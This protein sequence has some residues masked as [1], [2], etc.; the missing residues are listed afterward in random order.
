[1][2]TRVKISVRALAEY[3]YRGGSIESGFRAA[4]TLLDGTRA[5][6]QLQ[7]DYTERDR[8]EVHLEGRLA[9]EELV[10]ELE[11]RCD[12]LLIGEDGSVTIE[13]IKSTAA[14]LADIGEASHPVHWGQAM[15]YA[16]LYAANEGV[17]ALSIR[18]TYVHV[19][20]YALKRFTRRMEL[21]E[22]E[23][24]VRELVRAYAPFAR[25]QLRHVAERDRSCRALAFPYDAY[26]PGQ[27][28]LAGAVYKSAVDGK[29]LFAR[30]P[31][32]TG[33]TIST[34]FP[35]A[36][37]I[38]EGALDRFYYL[39]ARTITRTAAEEALALLEAKG[40]HLRSATLTAKEKICF[41][42]EMRCQKEFCEYADGYYDR[43]N[44]ALLDA[45]THE[46]R[47][48][49][50]VIET[51]ARK[52]RVCPFEFSLDA[53]YAADAVVCDYNYVFDPRVSF[54]RMPEETKR[55]TALLVDEA[56]NLVDR[57]REMFSAEL[58]KS[59]FLQL[60]RLWKT[61]NVGD[62][63][64]AVNDFFVGFRKAAGAERSVVTNFYPEELIPLVARF[65]E[66]AERTLLGSRASDGEA[67]ALLLET[68]FAALS[69]LRIAERYDE[70]YVTY[71]E[72]GKTDVRLKLF[73]L[74]PSSALRGMGKGYRSQAFFS[75]TLSPIS[76]Y[77]EMLGGEAED[78][79]V[80]VPSPFSKEQLEVQLLPVSTRYRDRASTKAPIADALRRLLEK[81]Q[82]NALAFFPSYDY[83][84]E[85]L[86][87]YLETGTPEAHVIVQRNGMSEEEREAFLAAFQPGG[88][89]RVLAF[90]V[91]GGIFSEGVD[92][93]L[94]RLG[95]V[96]VVGVGLPQVGLERE[97]MKAYFDRTGRNGFD[98]AYLYPGMTKVLQAGGR[99]IRTEED[100]GTLLL[101]DDRF[102][103][104]QYHRLLPEEWKPC[105]VI[106][107][108]SREGRS[109][110]A[111]L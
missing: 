105:A 22:L 71:A 95:V 36:K 92:L 62:A 48:T 106:G 102:L 100:R 77:R 37:A 24:A 61:E 108:A 46:T 3:A 82:G 79:H 98:F 87:A 40:L 39:T 88:A 60:R 64:K 35:A 10:F 94:D 85:V 32:G 55:R 2:E 58:T 97:V 53:A 109:S 76:Y 66:E 7:K 44:E 5:H 26:R 59:P 75:A 51:Y 43:I 14:E 27:R 69:F 15:C 8:K 80:A 17:P 110:R 31:T 91:M 38:G 12:G 74:D 65:G 13:E 81:R 70:A 11:G 1:M 19:P 78:Y 21:P 49:R 63:A 57:G 23:L 45:L 99:L 16:Y 67:L 68:Y 90:A 47:L 103:Q 104:P 52:H 9:Y 50:T 89:R 18:L 4:T 56:H 83:M 86:A 84:N 28:K 54:K 72:L 30:A 42:A 96:V 101:V 6:Q 20:S 33:K 25:L 73:C 107:H 111:Y 29:R 41:Q 93:T 34:I